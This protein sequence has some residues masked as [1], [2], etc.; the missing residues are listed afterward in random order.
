MNHVEIVEKLTNFS[1]NLFCLGSGRDQ[2]MS[3]Q[4]EGNAAEVLHTAEAEP[5][6]SAR[7][8][9]R[10]EGQAFRS[11][12]GRQDASNEELHHGNRVGSFYV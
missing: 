10:R 6:C 4:N 3:E 12:V 7:N 9:E 5:I 11:H 1:P 8:G 2:E